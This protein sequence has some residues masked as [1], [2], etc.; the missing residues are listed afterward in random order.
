M[1]YWES[2]EKNMEK[3]HGKKHGKS[4]EIGL[5]SKTVDCFITFK[6]QL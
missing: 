1:V 4:I 3:K 2:D 6:I 5:F